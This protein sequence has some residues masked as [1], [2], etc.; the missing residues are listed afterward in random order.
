MRKKD[1]PWKQVG[2]KKKQREKPRPLTG[3][4][5]EKAADFDVAAL[6]Y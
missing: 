2:K 5:L 4:G 6:V 1:R 3:K